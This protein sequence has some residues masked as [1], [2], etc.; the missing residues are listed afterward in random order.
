MVVNGDDS[1]RIP[2]QMY[3]GLPI[4]HAVEIGL[5]NLSMQYI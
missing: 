4:L 1:R 3:L 2:M 5:S